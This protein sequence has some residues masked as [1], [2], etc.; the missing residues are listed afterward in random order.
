MILVV[1]VQ[2]VVHIPVGP[3]RSWDSEIDLQ[4]LSKT[5]KLNATHIHIYYSDTFCGNSLASFP[6]SPHYW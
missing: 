4:R 5:S 3:Q 6:G 2:T 1:V